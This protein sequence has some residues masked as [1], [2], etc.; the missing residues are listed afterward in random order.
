MAAIHEDMT[1][2]KA[3]VKDVKDRVFKIKTDLAVL[4]WGIGL[5]AAGVFG[6]LLKAYAGF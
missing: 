2:L 6:L 1:E 4:K 3:D 5:T